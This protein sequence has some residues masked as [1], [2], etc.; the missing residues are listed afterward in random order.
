MSLIYLPDGWMRFGN[1]RK[2]RLAAPRYLCEIDDAGNMPTYAKSTS[3]STKIRR[4]K[5][6][7][8]GRVKLG[9][10]DEYGTGLDILVANSLAESLGTVPT[11]FSTSE[12]RGV[13]KGAIGIDAGTKLDALVRYVATHAKYLERREPGYVNPVT[14]PGRVSIGAHHVLISTAR[15]LLL[16]KANAPLD[17]Q[18]SDITD[19]VCRLPAE[20][21]YAAELAVQYFN[22]SYARHRNQ[23]PLLAATYNAGS[24]RPDATNPWNLR[25]YGNHLD[26]WTTFYNTSRML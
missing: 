13:L 6:F 5:S 20:S 3:V 17:Q 8:S 19:L 24:P 21:L 25:Q 22:Q 26:R 14:T 18:I 2:W 9:A 23:P 10:L 15:R 12:L 16:Q 4:I 11:P 7:Y 1:G